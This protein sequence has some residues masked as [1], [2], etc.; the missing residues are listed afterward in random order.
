MEPRIRE[1]FLFIIEDTNETSHDSLS[2]PEE[3]FDPKHMRQYSGTA[4]EE[5]APATRKKRAQTATVY[6][7]KMK[8]NVTAMHYGQRIGEIYQ[9]WKRLEVLKSGIKWH[10]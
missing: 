2:S 1:L 7:Y 5:V 10:K 3:P 8:D 9:S 4:S 6:T